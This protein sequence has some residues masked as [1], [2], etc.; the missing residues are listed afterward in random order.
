MVSNSARTW[1]GLFI[2]LIAEDG[3]VRMILSVASSAHGAA[4]ARSEARQVARLVTPDL[5]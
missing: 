3:T 1:S 5:K 2:A 4:S